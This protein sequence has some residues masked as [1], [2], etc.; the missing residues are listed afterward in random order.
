MRDIKFRAWDKQRR[1][2]LSGGQVLIAILQGKCPE[3]NPIYLDVLQGADAYRDRF[4]LE[5]FTGSYDR[6][7]KRIYEGDILRS[8]SRLFKVDWVQD[9]FAAYDDD[10]N[11]GPLYLYAGRGIV[12]G[13]IYD[14]PE[15]MEATACRK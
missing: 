4:I 6:N 9:G 2:Y 14:N 5:Q 13:N 15:L 12:I 7:E 1:E 11:G 10:G 8:Q 3:H